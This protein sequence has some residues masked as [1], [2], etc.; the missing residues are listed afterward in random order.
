LVKDIARNKN[1][2]SSFLDQFGVV[3]PDNYIR[4]ARH[5]SKAYVDWLNSLPLPEESMKQTLENYLEMVLLLR[6]QQL[7][8]N[9]QIKEL[10]LGED[11]KRNYELLLSVPGIGPTVAAMIITELGDISRFATVDKLSCFI[12]LV[13][14]MHG[15]GDKMV[16]GKM[17]HR[18]RKQ[19]KIH[20]I[21]ASWQA[22][23]KDPA[24]MLKFDQLSKTMHKNKAIVRVARS[25]LNRIRHVLINQEEY[26][27]GVTS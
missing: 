9:K 1:R 13:P 16:V 3:I 11:Y 7:R 8:I 24:L 21:E 25:L 22:I 5:F 23:R 14:S 20:L 2:I 19:L 10:M 4:N 27:I 26:V 15:S 12:G 6:K 18:G 17:V